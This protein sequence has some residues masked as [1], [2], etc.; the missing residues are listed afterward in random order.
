MTETIGLMCLSCARELLSQR[1]VREIIADGRPHGPFCASCAQRAE[2][3]P[4]DQWLDEEWHRQHP[5]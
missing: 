1:D 5:H 2:V 4:L 3:L